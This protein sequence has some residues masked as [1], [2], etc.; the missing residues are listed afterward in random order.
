MNE[1]P[2][3][4]IGD[5]HGHLDRLEALLKQEGIIQDCPYSGLTRINHDVCCVQLGDL[6]H[7][8]YDTGARDRSIWGAAPS[9]L[10]VIL[11][12]NHDR[13]VWDGRH[14]FG[15][16]S[17]A[18]PE[19]FDIIKACEKEGKLRLAHEAHGFL[20]THAGL[21]AAYKH[22]KA[23]QDSAA[24]TVEWLL[25]REAEDSQDEEFLAIRDNIGA[26]RGGRA[27]AGGILWRDASESLYPAYRQ[28]FGHSAKDESSTRTYQSK[29]AGDS[30]CIDVGNKYNGRLKGMWLPEC[31]V[32]EVKLERDQATQ[33]AEDA[34]RRRLAA[35]WGEPQL[36]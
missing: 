7:Y 2:T 32:V 6:G 28:V 16:Y 22:N 27:T 34:A 24:A 11:W 14:H 9:W 15:G 31:K 29:E 21:H 20:L 25:A 33:D 12:G 30:Y 36:P 1:K 4:V 35:R 19:T 23:P 3:L 10:D 5:C 17:P 8:G 18:F 13:A 26:R